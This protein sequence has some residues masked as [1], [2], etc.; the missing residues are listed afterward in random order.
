[1]KQERILF[2]D[3][4]VRTESRTRQ[5]AEYVLSKL[6]GEAET[7]RLANTD[8]APLTREQME[9]RI[10]LVNASDYSDPMFDCA[11]SFAAAD[12][13]LIAAPYWDLSFP[14]VLKAFLEQICVIGLTFGYD[15][16]D[17]PISFCKAHRLIYVTTA[18]GP[19]LSDE[20][21]YGYVRALANTFFHI[22]DTMQFKA[23]CLDLVGA[24][25][26]KI[27]EKAKESVIIKL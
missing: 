4:C 8:I 1:M 11:K 6:N 16:K 19:I 20:Y 7:I 2:V 25:V 23:E 21:G 3:A 22:Q 18:G 27:L 9:K 12:T 5:L 14:S 26:E 13:I 17:Q 10:A 24:D 15:E